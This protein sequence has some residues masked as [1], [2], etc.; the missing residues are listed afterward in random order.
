[1]RV[2]SDRIGKN[3]T[4]VRTVARWQGTESYGALPTLARRLTKRGPAMHQKRANA[5]PFLQPGDTVVL[6][7]GTCKLCN[8]WAK[9]IIAHDRV[10]R[11]QLSAVQSAEGQALLAWAGLPQHEFNTIVLIAENQIHIRS[12][13]MLEIAARLPWYWHWLGLARVVPRPIRDWLYDKIAL[14]RYR[15]FGRYDSCR[16]PTPD[17]PERFLRGREPYVPASTGQ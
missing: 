15:L 8:G 7:D 13:A 6:F 12:D 11:I 3:E 4:N 5:A 16:T 14:N 17:H 2:S 1:M 9:L 10:R